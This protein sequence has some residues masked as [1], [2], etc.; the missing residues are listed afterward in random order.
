[1]NRKFLLLISILIIAIGITGLFISSEND[2]KIT[3][4]L[5]TP[6]NEKEV[7]IILA[8]A[9]SDLPSGTLLTHSEYAIKKIAVPESS[10]L[11]KNDISETPNINSYL[12]KTNT[13]NG[14]YITKDMLATP[15]SDEFNHLS[16]QKGYIVYKFTTKKQDDYLLNTLSVGDEISYQLRVLETDNKKG[17]EHGT[18]INTKNMSDRKK[19]SYSLNKIIPNMKVVRIKKYSADELSEKN[20][21]NQ[22]TEDML[23]GYIAVTIKIE[24]LDLIHIVEKTG[25]TFLT[26]NYKNDDSKR[27]STNLYDIIPKLRTA[28]ELRG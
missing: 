13:L 22:K 20:S 12:L 27:I 7:T 14:S 19:Q 23:T 25:D 18:I 2:E 17:M 10:E 6:K 15:N 1:M 28:R 9:T 3:S 5:L 11:I 8:Q 4:S 26:P 16:L 24:E 21:K